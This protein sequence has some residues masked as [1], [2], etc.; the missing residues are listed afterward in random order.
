MSLN[1]RQ[2][3]F[4]N[5][6]LIDLNGTQAAIRAGYSKKTAQEIAAQNLTK[7][8]IKKALEEKQKI[9]SDETLITQKYVLNNLKHVFD[10]NSKE[11][12]QVDMS[13]NHRS[14]MKNPAVA[15]KAIE[16]LGK[17]L[18]MF[19]D[20]V[21]HSLDDKTINILSFADTQKILTGEIV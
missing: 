19:T 2:E 16:L 5:E 12:D 3:K 9:L 20:K 18:G 7:P 21:E 4:I 13:G 14:M 10:Y 15:V 8:S 1:A 17:H 11:F 6:Y